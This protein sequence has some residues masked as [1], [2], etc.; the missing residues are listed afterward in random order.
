M[1]KPVLF[2]KNITLEGPGIMEMFLRERN[3]AYEIRDLY[4]G[5]PL[6]EEISNYGAAV[7]LGG[8]MNVEEE[9][10]YP[11]LQQEKK[12]IGDCLQKK[13]PVLGICLGAQLLACTLSARVYKNHRA[14][15]GCMTVDLTPAGEKSPL[16]FGISSPAEVFQWHGDTFDLPDC[17]THLAQSPFCPHQAFGY[18][19]FAFGVQFH[20]EVTLE[21]AQKWA[22]MYLP[23]LQGEE[24]KAAREL[25]EYSK[26]RWPEEIERT[27][28][29][30]CRNFFGSIAKLLD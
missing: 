6:P 3:I 5:E 8:P 13:I 7:I 21:E 14:E 27:A 26:E 23:D 4:A 17:A 16:F 2:V 29:K 22:A 10:R 20:I 30:L 1:R 9:L 28:E 19:E 15:I 25:I 18:E 24:K 11:F 12:L